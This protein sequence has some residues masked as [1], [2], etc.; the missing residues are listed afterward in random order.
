[1]YLDL[2][3]LP[4]TPQQLDEFLHDKSPDAYDSMV[5]QALQSPHYGER[6]ARH[7]LDLARYADSDG[8]EKDRP[9]P[10][11][12]RYR[13]WVIEAL[14]ENMPFDAFTVHQIAGDMLDG[15]AVAQR[16]A[17]GFH[18]NTLHNTEGGTDKEE[19][20]VKK[21]VDRINTVGSVWMGLTVGCAQC[22]THK[23]DPISQREYYQLYGFFN[24]IDEQDVPAPTPE[25]EKQHAEQL[26]THAAKAKQLEA[27]RE[28]YLREQLAAAQATWEATAAATAA[29]WS[30][31][32]VIE[33]AS[34]HSAKLETAKDGVIFVSGENR[35]ADVYTIKFKATS[36]TAAIHQMNVHG[37]CDVRPDGGAGLRP[38]RYVR[39]EMAIHDIDVDP[40]AALGLDGAAFGTEIREIGTEYRCGDFDLAI[41]IRHVTPS[42]GFTTTE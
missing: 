38:E 18:R 13:Q 35:V 24:H 33:T 28:T 42:L 36:P 10:N 22:H 12:W 34:K 37:G 15:A 26:A 3:G 17:T 16:V 4:P 8:Y 41:E 31:V 11:A 21:T 30:D 20:R 14:N 7:W 40:V 6:W 39:H 5:T 27:Q 2:L 1:M 29:A 32:S 19:D 25:E 9:R 23:Y